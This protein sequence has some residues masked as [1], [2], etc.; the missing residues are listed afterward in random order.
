MLSIEQQKKI[1]KRIEKMKS[2]KDKDNLKNLM[3]IIRDNN[4]QYYET[5]NSGGILLKFNEL[6]E[7]THNEIV[8]WLEKIDNTRSM[9][10]ECSEDVIYKSPKNKQEKSPKHIHKISD[11][12]LKPTN[13]E[14]QVINKLKYQ[15][16][17]KDNATK[18]IDD[19]SESEINN[20]FVKT[21]KN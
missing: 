15:K 19:S 2:K 13:G 14:M 18:S 21:I 7:K 20:I 11:K 5:K 8:L 6:T 9:L 17:L 12:K 3:K 16:I 10:S 4:P 1:V